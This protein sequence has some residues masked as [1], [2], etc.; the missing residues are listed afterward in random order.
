MNIDIIKSG[1]VI[2]H[3]K[4]GNAI[5][6]YKLLNLNE[7]D[8]RVVLITNTKSKKM[9]IKDMIKIDKLINL[10]LDA[11]AYIDSNITINVVKKS[12]VVEKKK[13]KLPNRLIN[14][15]K[16]NNPRCITS[17][18]KDIDNVFILSDNGI[19]KCMY[20]ENILNRE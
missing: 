12:R 2:D 17:Q 20:C 1:Y 4:S 16:C 14:I 7:L 6:I 11:L 5:K 8:C 3:I 9:K 10:N 13:I 19:Y 15:E 18:E